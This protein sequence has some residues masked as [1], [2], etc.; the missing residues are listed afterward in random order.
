MEKKATF[1]NAELAREMAARFGEAHEAV[2][3][4]MNFSTEVESFV[5]KI[6]IA[7]RQAANSTLVFG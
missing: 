5:R 2:K 6:E 1:G 4:E 3:V 7:R